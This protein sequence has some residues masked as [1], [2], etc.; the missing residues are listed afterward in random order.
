MLPFSTDTL[1]RHESSSDRPE[2]SP[3]T[4]TP[5]RGGYH[6]GPADLFTKS[7]M[8]RLP[9]PGLNDSGPVEEEMRRVAD[10][11]DELEGIRHKL[12]TGHRPWST[13]EQAKTASTATTDRHVPSQK[14]EWS[15]GQA[16]WTGAPVFVNGRPDTPLSHHEKRSDMDEDGGQQDIN[17]RQAQAKTVRETCSTPDPRAILGPLCAM[18]LTVTQHHLGSKPE[19]ESKSTEEY[20]WDAAIRQAAKANEAAIEVVGYPGCITGLTLEPHD[21]Q[22]GSH[23]NSEAL[24]HGT[25]VLPLARERVLTREHSGAVSDW[26]SRENLPYRFSRRHVATKK[27]PSSPC[28]FP[29]LLETLAAP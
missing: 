15:G 1:T 4:P 13:D 11:A 12:A 7:A 24:I 20:E 25:E 9:A 18:T 3:N 27:S 10:A 6:S 26:Q 2:H 5:K 21:L 23:G 28:T 19:Q 14:S 16:C 17:G 22:G 29:I 8:A